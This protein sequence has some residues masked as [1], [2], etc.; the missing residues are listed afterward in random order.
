MDR[1]SELIKE[2]AAKYNTTIEEV[3][4]IFKQQFWCVNEVMQEG[5]H[6]GI[7]L[8]YFGK[9]YVKPNRK[10]LF[11]ETLAIQKAKR[12]AKRNAHKTK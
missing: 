9:F 6:Q 1:Q 5:S 3:E 10:R 2:I 4:T 11:E 12:E 8:P 7:M